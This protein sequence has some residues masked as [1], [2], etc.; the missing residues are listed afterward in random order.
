MDTELQDFQCMQELKVRCSAYVL[1]ILLFCA[2]IAPALAESQD[3]VST[4]NVRVVS[5]APSITEIIFALNAQSNLV[6]VTRFCDFPPEAVKLPKIGGLVDPNLESILS[7]K[8]DIVLGMPEHTD[9][10]AALSR[11]NVRTSL[12]RQGSIQEIIDSIV[13][14]GT[15]IGREQEAKKLTSKIQ[16]HLAALRESATST[17][18]PRVLVSVGGHV[19]PGALDSIYAAGP[20]TLY[21]ELLRIAGGRNVLQ[22]GTEYAKLS[23][24]GLL[25]LNPD[26][27]ID[28][29]PSSFGANPEDR[30]KK[31]SDT[32]RAWS[33]LENLKAVR[34]QRV[35]VLDQDFVVNPG[36]R[37][38]KTLELFSEAIRPQAGDY[39]QR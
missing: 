15:L 3:S 20:G 38:I 30:L 5:L 18:Q 1:S 22:S 28:L 32:I 11:F 39:A 23:S 8:A 27:I 26:V 33:S 6:G 31:R 37:T 19:R 34:T 7:V 25:D 12:Y 2:S 17:V 14:I 4:G 10:A 16:A 24:E 35:Y 36:P 29:V 21:D 13:G 9:I